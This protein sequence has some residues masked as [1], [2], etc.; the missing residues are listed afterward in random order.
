MD[1]G[2]D[3]VHLQIFKAV[4]EERTHGL[5]H[6]ARALPLR[7][8]DVADCRP[9]VVCLAMVVVDHADARVALLVGDRPSEERIGARALCKNFEPARALCWRP[10]GWEVPVAHGLRVAKAGVEAREV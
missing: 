6:E 8:K 9:T 3:A 1:Q 4:G 7:A 2:L 10:R 5:G